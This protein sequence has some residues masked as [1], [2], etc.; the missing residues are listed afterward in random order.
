MSSFFFLH[1]RTTTTKENKTKACTRKGN[2]GKPESGGFQRWEVVCLRIEIVEE[3]FHHTGGDAWPCGVGQ[4]NPMWLL[5]TSKTICLP[6]LQIRAIAIG[7]SWVDEY[8]DG[9]WGWWGRLQWWLGF[10]ISRGLGFNV[11]WC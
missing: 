11:P 1:I 3:D 9:G 7:A 6:V 10:Q 8:V 4:E 5:K 2:V